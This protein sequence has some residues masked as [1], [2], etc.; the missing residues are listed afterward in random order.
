M[1]DADEPRAAVF[2]MDG[3]LVVARPQATSVIRSGGSCQR[4]RLFRL[5]IWNHLERVA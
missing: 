3:A 5:K 1:R 2:D 4:F